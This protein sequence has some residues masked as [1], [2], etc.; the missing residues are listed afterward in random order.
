MTLCTR[1]GMP[2][3]RGGKST[4]KHPNECWA[5]VRKKIAR[6]VRLNNAA[7]RACANAREAIKGADSIILE[8]MLLRRELRLLAE[9]D[10]RMG[11]ATD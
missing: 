11:A 3:K 9:L 6:L 4:H 7:I 5:L 10:C 8:G 1:C 2:L